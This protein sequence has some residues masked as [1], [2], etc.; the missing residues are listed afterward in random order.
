MENVPSMATK[1][2]QITD[3]LRAT[4]EALGFELWGVEYLSQGGHSLRDLY[5]RR[6]GITVEDCAPG[7]PAG[8][9]C[10]GCGRPDYRRVHA[11]GVFPGDGSPVVQAGP[12]SRA[13]WVRPWS[14]VCARRL[15]AAQI[16]GDFNRH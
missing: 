7:Q 5:R 14:C 11:G 12:V 3:L 10:A 8:G 9:K 15:R 1:D 13:S 6:K 4:V 2:Q 16:Q